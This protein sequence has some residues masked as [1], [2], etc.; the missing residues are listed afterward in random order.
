VEAR[1]R[2]DGRAEE[3]KDVAEI[4]CLMSCA[5]NWPGG[6]RWIVLFAQCDRG[7]MHVRLQFLRAI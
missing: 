2:Q 7:H 3:D 4:T 6:L 1:R 5:G